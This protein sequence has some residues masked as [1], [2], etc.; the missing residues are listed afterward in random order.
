MKLIFACLFFFTVFIQGFSQGERLNDFSFIV[1]PQQF[2][3]QYE[4]D[5]YQLNSLLKYLFNKN[6][7]HA[8]FDTELPDVR[9]CDGLR[10]E[11]I[12]TPGFVWTELVI[13]IKDCDG[14]LLY[15]TAVGKSKLKE[16]NKAYTEALRQ[17][18]E[19][20]EVLGV[21]QKE[22]SVLLN[23][24]ENNVIQDTAVEEERGKEMNN[25]LMLPTTKYSNYSFNNNNYLLRKTQEGFR[26]YEEGANG[27]ED[28]IY[29]GKAFE[30]SGVL[31]FEAANEERFLAEFDKEGNFLIKL[32][33]TEKKYVRTN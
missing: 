3:F 21:R 10:A 13:K 14:I 33:G 17:A 2:D 5:Q 7:F 28:L 6:G 23:T 29:I 26:L 16:Y 20:I 25:P 4:V 11:V 8:F 30:V 19:S 22:V 9:R 32:N 15:Q 12:G 18:F 1:V 24:S 31:F 27:E